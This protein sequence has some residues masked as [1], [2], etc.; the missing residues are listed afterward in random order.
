M[1][2]SKTLAAALAACLALLPAGLASAH[3][4]AHRDLARCSAVAY[5]PRQARSGRLSFHAS[6]CPTRAGRKGTHHGKRSHLLFFKAFGGRCPDTGLTPDAQDVAQIRAATLCLV[7]RERA[8]DGEHPLRWNNHLVAAAQAHTES[9]AFEGYFEHIGPHGETPLMRMRHAGYIYSANIGFEV[10]EN[11]AWGSLSL[12]T[13]RAIVAGWMGSYGHRANILDAN[14]R[15][16][17]IGIS[18]HLGLLAPGES[19]GIYTQD[20]GVIVTG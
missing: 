14:Y 8:R 9:M 4:P 12:S 13:P 5:A 10:G 20:F 11:I 17:G 6:H 2:G 15:E 7:N 3:T 1:F 19:G 16:T 18:P